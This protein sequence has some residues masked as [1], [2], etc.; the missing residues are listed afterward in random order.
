MKGWGKIKWNNFPVYSL[1]KSFRN[2]GT[3]YIMEME[4]IGS[5]PY[6][7]FNPEFLMKPLVVDL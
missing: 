5:F 2:S 3:F 7:N 4:K 1:K 6:V